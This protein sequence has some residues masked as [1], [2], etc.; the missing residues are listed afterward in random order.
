MNNKQITVTCL[1]GIVSVLFAPATLASSIFIGHA[2][3]QRL[4]SVAETTQELS[5][6]GPEAFFS[7]DITAKWSISV[8]YSRLQDDE[9]INNLVN[10]D[11]EFDSAALGLSYFADDWAVSYQF[12]DFEEQ[13]DTFGNRPDAPGLFRN[14]QGNSHS[15]T[16]SYFISLNENWQMSSS[17]GLHLNDWDEARQEIILETVASPNGDTDTRI[18]RVDFEESGDSSLISFSANINRYSMLSDNTGFTFGAF[19][20]W[21]EVLDSQSELQSINNRNINTARGVGGRGGAIN[22]FLI[23]GGESYGIASLY[24]SFDFYQNWVVDLDFNTDYGTDDSIQTWSLG[25]GY[26]F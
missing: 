8:D 18:Q 21:N 4:V 5:P 19:L 11:Y 3:T 15:L 10:L 26:I 20:G 9:T 1:S 22:N 12:T 2:N 23:T 16:A 6:S 7:Y 25:V 17:L 24:L 14:T 13:Q